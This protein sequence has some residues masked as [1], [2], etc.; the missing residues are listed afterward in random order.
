MEGF[1]FRRFNIIQDRC[2][3][4]VGTDGVLLG[5]WANGGNKILDIGTGTAL[6]ALMMAQRFEQAKI[7]AIDIDEMACGQAKENVDC[8][9][10]S[11][12]IE[13]ACCA[14]QDFKQ[15]SFDAIVCNPPFFTSSL[16]CP[17]NRRTMARHEDALSVADLMKC[18]FRLLTNSGEL[19]LIIPSN[20][21]A[22][23]DMHAAFVGVYVSRVYAIKTVEHK[24]IGRYLLA[25][26]KTPVGAIDRR[27]VCLCA[28]NG[29]R[30][31]WYSNLTSDFYIK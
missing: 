13:V 7:T 23:F 24:P 22:D 28:Q 10:F 11:D 2:A 17:D 4:K 18:A 15:D 21:K 29:S 9:P 5:A 14:L 30:S 6:I 16:K 26:S 12:R 3:M 19:S 8:S 1:T 31:Q 20:R 25:Y 27:E